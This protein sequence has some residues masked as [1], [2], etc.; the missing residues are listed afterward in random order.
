MDL[1]NSK[2]AVNLW[3]VLHFCFGLL[4]ASFSYI[5]GLGLV[6]CLYVASLLA[7]IW[8]IYERFKGTDESV[9]NS[10]FDILA[11]IVASCLAY[12]LITYFKKFPYVPHVLIIGS[13]VAYIIFY[14]K[15]KLYL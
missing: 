11:T 7:V 10:L 3:T 5:A 4:V 6:L 12:Y 14:M 9:L 1:W 2:D 8:E 15:G 13:V